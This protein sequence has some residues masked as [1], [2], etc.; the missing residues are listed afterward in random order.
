MTAV[1]VQHEND[2]NFMS[3]AEVKTV[4]FSLVNITIFKIF[5]Y[6]EKLSVVIGMKMAAKFFKMPTFQAFVNLNGNLKL[7]RS[8]CL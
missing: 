1:S 2:I 6:S 8:W 7:P 5:T 4:G 3:S